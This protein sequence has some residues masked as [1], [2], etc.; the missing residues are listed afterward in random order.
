MSNLHQRF[1]HLLSEIELIARLTESQS[2]A[3]N[4]HNALLNQ[5]KALTLL[6]NQI[7]ALQPRADSYT[8]ATATVTEL[9]QQL[10]SLY[11]DHQQLS[12]QHRE[13]ECMAL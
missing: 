2:H 11:K 12:V 7:A 8:V 9:K 6:T 4:Q 1:C 10:V 13:S 5:S 3:L